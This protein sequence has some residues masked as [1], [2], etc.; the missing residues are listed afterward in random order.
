MTSISVLTVQNSVR[1]GLCERI[2]YGSFITFFFAGPRSGTKLWLAEIF[3][4][5]LGTIA[6]FNSRLRLPNM[7][8]K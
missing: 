3:A 8:H 4:K 2:A 6:P 1:D 5:S 7:R